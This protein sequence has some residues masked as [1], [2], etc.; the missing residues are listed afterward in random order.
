MCLGGG[1]QRKLRGRTAM[2]AP[3]GGQAQADTDFSIF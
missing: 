2:G 1:E 3:M